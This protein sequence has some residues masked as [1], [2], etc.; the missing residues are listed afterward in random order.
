MNDLKDIVIVG[1]GGLGREIVSVITACNTARKEWNVLGFLDSNHNLVGSRLGGV[2]V[3][4]SDE[5]CQKNSYRPVSFVCAIGDPKIR[6]QIA[7]R[8]SGVG[9]K[10]ASVVH[11]D[12]RI[13]H[14]VRIGAG[15]VVMAGTQ[16]TTDANVGSHVVIYLN[17]SITHDV[18]IG[19]FCMIAPGCNL[20]GGTVLEK[21]VQ[22]GSG[23]ST[24]PG[25]R[26]G[27]WAIIGAGS[28]VTD[29]IPANCTAVGAPC[30]VI[31]T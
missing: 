16:F 22:L 10:F 5:W 27:A 1:A 4:G 12:V 28:V 13:P 14:S 6:R 25:R 30:R 29:D 19:D 20:S 3:L 24:L 23:V 21:G 15:T 18:E 31:R 9:C 7:E 17:C 26:M 2:P 8:F 11:P